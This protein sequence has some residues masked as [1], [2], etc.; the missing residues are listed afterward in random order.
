MDSEL[1]IAG[2]HVSESVVAT[3]VTE[4]VER[5]EGI[6]SVGTNAIASGLISVF[7][8]CPQSTEPPVE[9]SVEDNK[10]HVSVHLSV[11]YGYPFTKLAQDV[12]QAVAE[13]V[14]SQMGVEC[15]SV[16]VCIDHLVFPRE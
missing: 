10:L 11:F 1:T 8:A 13:A 3:I 6:A 9:A 4:A 2:I 14:A 15:G 12:R 7:T 5:V 16:D